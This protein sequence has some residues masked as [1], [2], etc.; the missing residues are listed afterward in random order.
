MIRLNSALLAL[1]GAFA[2]TYAPFQAIRLQ[3]HSSGVLVAA[4]DQGRITAFGFD[5]KGSADE[6]CNLL[7][8]PELLRACSGIKSA[9][10]DVAITEDTATVTTYRKNGNHEVKSFPISQAS[11][12]FPPLDQAVAIC[13]R[14]WGAAPATSA[15]AGRYD[16]L[17]LEQALKTVSHLCESMVISGFDGGPLRLQSEA[18]DLMILIMPQTAEPIP[19]LPDWIQQFASPQGEPAS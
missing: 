19:P 2:G 6:S 1:V 16:S 8:G 10:R 11:T 14:R 17:Y 13:I 18:L 9:E 5:P 4:S 15:T 3:P 12:P 7:A